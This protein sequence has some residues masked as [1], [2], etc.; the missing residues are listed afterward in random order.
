MA[1]RDTF[2][3][4]DRAESHVDGVAGACPHRRGGCRDDRLGGIHAAFTV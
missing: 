4:A 3:A 1:D 2:R